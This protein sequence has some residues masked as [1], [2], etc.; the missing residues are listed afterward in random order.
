MTTSVKKSL[1]AILSALFVLCLIFVGSSL[2]TNQ[3]KATDSLNVVTLEN[4]KPADHVE[5]R[6]NV[7]TGMRFVTKISAADLEKNQFDQ[8]NTTVVT[9]ITPKVY[10]DRA[11]IDVNNFDKDSAVRYSVVAY[12]LSEL[13]L[14]EDGLYT[15]KAVLLEVKDKNVMQKFVAKTYVT[16]G[17]NIGYTDAQVASIFDVANYWLEQGLGAEDEQTQAILDRYGKCEH[18]EYVDGKC[19]KCGTAC[20][21]ESFES[22][23]C[24][25]CGFVCTHEVCENGTCT[26][27]Q[28]LVYKRDGNY[29]YF[30][31]YPQTIKA[32]SVTVSSTKNAN[33]YYV[34][35]DGA[36]YATSLGDADGSNYKFSNGETISTGKKKTYYFKVE[37]IR[38]K[39]I[40]EDDGTVTLLCDNI[41]NNREFDDDRGYWGDSG[42][43][44][45]LNNNFYNQAFNSYE[46]N[47]IQI[48]KVDN[49]PASTG[50]TGN[51]NAWGTYDD[52][53]YLLSVVEAQKLSSSNRKI[54]TSDYARSE[55]AN[56][57]TSSSTYGNGY[58]WLRSADPYSKYYARIYTPDGSNSRSGVDWW[59]GGVAPALK[60][61]K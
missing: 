13:T 56:M 43:R 2:S 24:L 29:I 14:D 44:T 60:I 19:S 4:S 6:L 36:E 45:W 5:M 32:S 42:I 53:I 41:L 9:M 10:L 48:T 11:E 23:I 47:F 27:C 39:I 22:G 28:Y 21:H 17:V 12:K 38:W 54:L 35:S 16:D 26:K 8:E 57:S 59:Q 52:K 15:V 55:G 31:R 30:G 34:G 46:K 1:I 37:L 33:G 49:S 20:K 61:K 51:D 58:W 25:V 3:A 7:P 50:D 18:P 40:G